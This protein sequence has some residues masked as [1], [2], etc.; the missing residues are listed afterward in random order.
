MT[1]T[2]NHLQTFNLVTL[3]EIRKIRRKNSSFLNDH[4]NLFWDEIEAILRTKNPSQKNEWQKLDNDDV[5]LGDVWCQ[6]IGEF[7]YK[8][9]V[10]KFTYLYIG[11]QGL[12][13]DEHGHE[14]PANNG[15][16]IRKIKEWYI[17]PDGTMSL[18]DKDETHKLF[19]RSENP[20][21]VISVKISSNGN[22]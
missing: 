10:H 4:Y 2:R 11:S 5:I 19:N 7:Y 6:T 8:H 20:I 15:K 9:T 17:F 12:A 16:Q 13:I 3:R 22:R 1:S 21:Y 14:E 18:C